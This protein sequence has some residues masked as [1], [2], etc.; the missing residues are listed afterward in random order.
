MRESFFDELV[1]VTGIR[2]WSP[3]REPKLLENEQEGD[4]RTY[5]LLSV[6]CRV[7]GCHELGEAV[8]YLDARLPQAGMIGLFG[9]LRWNP[10]ESQVTATCPVC[11][12]F[13]TTPLQRIS[14]DRLERAFA[15]MVSVGSEESTLSG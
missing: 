13:A 10:T 4:P 15:A 9:A 1:T 14:R 3:A 7:D 6:R 5:V 11:T 2:A 12:M 8:Y